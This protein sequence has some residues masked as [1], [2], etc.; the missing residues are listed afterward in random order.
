VVNPACGC[1]R[2]RNEEQNP[3]LHCSSVERNKE[4]D[5]FVRFRWGE[6]KERDAV[7]GARLTIEIGAEFRFSRTFDDQGS[8]AGAAVCVFQ[9]FPLVLSQPGAAFIETAAEPEFP[10][11]PM[12]VLTR[13]V[14][15]VLHR[16]PEELEPTRF[17]V[18]KVA[19]ELVEDD[20]RRGP[21]M[22]CLRSDLMEMRTAPRYC[23]I[24]DDSKEPRPA[25]S[26][27]G[28]ALLSEQAFKKSSTVTRP[29]FLTDYEPTRCV[30]SMPKLPD[31]RPRRGVGGPCAA[32]SGPWSQPETDDTLGTDNHDRTDNPDNPAPD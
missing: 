19:G 11:G 23:G 31:A 28:A 12:K 15:V 21:D 4:G 22:D 7:G 24:T 10:I 26:D 9:G 17:V 6:T 29:D 32:R 16:R 8:P 20:Q 14:L 1:S 25:Q 3:G 13:L 2:D 27:T 18:S 5:G 30:S